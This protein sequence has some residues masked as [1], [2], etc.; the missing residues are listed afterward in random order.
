MLYKYSTL[1]LHTSIAYLIFHRLGLGSDKAQNPLVNA[2]RILPDLRPVL[3]KDLHF[4]AG[5]HYFSISCM[6]LLQI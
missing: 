6:H 2:Y 1:S 3:K 4:R 5:A